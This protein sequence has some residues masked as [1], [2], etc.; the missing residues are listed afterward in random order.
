MFHTELFSK[1]VEKYNPEIYE[2]FKYNN[3]KQIYD[4]LPSISID[5]G[6]M[7]KSR[8]IAVL[9]LKI[10]WNDLGSF[11]TFYDEYEKDENGNICFNS[12]ILM[13]S[14]NNLLYTDKNK[15]VAKA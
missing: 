12:N 7:E 4:K 1:E 13:D 3:V 6:I 10:K 11:A 5:Y 8:K 14:S 9:P 15:T 2:A